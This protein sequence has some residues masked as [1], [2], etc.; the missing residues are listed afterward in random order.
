MT[1]YFLGKQTGFAFFNSF[2]IILVICL[3]SIWFIVSLLSIQGALQGRLL[4][5]PVF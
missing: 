5:D 3:V 4:K 2:S 1:T